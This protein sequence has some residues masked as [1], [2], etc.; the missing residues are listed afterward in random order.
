[1]ISKD[2]VHSPLCVEKIITKVFDMITNHR[3]TS[4]PYEA[5]DDEESVTSSDFVK[6][7]SE[8][9]ELTYGLIINK[10]WRVI[11]WNFN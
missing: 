2:N 5:G 9:R 1:M 7:A 6:Y 4:S 3:S 11:K 8:Q 10:S